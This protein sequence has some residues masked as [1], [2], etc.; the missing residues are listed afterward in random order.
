MFNRSDLESG[1]V[2][3]INGQNF[4]TILNDAFE[5]F[6][7]SDGFIFL[8]MYDHDLKYQYPDN[9]EWNIAKVYSFNKEGGLDELMKVENSEILFEEEVSKKEIKEM[10]L[11]EIENQLGFRIKI[12]NK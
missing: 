2:V 12:V 5:G 3:E 8:D 9:P 4:L 10:T 11:T 6:M 7:A 1:M